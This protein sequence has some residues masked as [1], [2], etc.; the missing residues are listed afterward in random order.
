MT[1]YLYLWL[2]NSIFWGEVVQG[3]PWKGEFEDVKVE[4]KF[5]EVSPSLT[6]K[7]SLHSNTRFIQNLHMLKSYDRF[8]LCACIISARDCWN[9][10]QFWD[11]NHCSYKCPSL[12][13]PP[14]TLKLALLLIIIDV[15]WIAHAVKGTRAF[16]TNVFLSMQAFKII[17][18]EKLPHV[19]E[20]VNAICPPTLSCT[21][22]A[23]FQLCRSL[24]CIHAE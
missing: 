22:Q 10:G 15:S 7:P 2:V 1:V 5:R 16:V 8:H 21:F 11:R 17:R 9:S 14:D 13:G 19:C 3:S 12:R 20:L 24:Q 6:M 18:Q 4:R 23:H